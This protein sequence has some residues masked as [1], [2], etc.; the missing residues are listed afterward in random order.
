MAMTSPQQHRRRTGSL[1]SRIAEAGLILAALTLAAAALIYIAG[2]DRHAMAAPAQLAKLLANPADEPVGIPADQLADPE[3]Y[4]AR[5]TVDLASTAVPVDADEAYITVTL[6]GRSANTVI[7]YIRCFDGGGASPVRDHVQ[8]VFFRSGDPLETTVSCAVRTADEGD[9]MFFIQAQ[10][11]DGAERGRDRAEAVFAR[12]GTPPPESES[13]APYRFAPRGEL[14]YDAAGSAVAFSDSGGPREW[15]TSLPHGR[16]QPANGETGYYGPRA[17]GGYRVEGGDLNIVSKRLPS[18]VAA[19]ESGGPFP[20]LA[21]TLSA[22]KAENL[23]FRY[24]SMEWEAIMP[25][26]RGSWP[27]LWLL[28]VSGWPP[29]ID[30]YEGFTYNSEWRPKSSLS[31][32]IHGGTKGKRLFERGAFRMRMEH[33][34]LEP[35]LTSEFHK[36]QVTVDPAWITMFVDGVETMRYA[37]GFPGERWFPLMQVAVKT[38][39][40]DSYDSG[41]GTM[42][43][44]RVKIWRAE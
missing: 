24:G 43:V 10:V 4:P 2:S 19:N 29:E 11:P 38:P 42:T 5:V 14:V 12:D 23:Q 8:P 17:L 9:R 15:S 20:F 34:G 7:A 40:G 18:P 1:Q 16:T 22:H 3:S 35:T 41:S 32:N 27:A 25:G 6:S 39:R 26:R 37:N 30:V 31:T 13:R 21:A 33:F 36:F 28:P 44:R